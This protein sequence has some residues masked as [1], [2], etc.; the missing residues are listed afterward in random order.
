MVKPFENKAMYDIYLPDIP[1][2]KNI[3]KAINGIKYDGNNRI[4]SDAEEL[5]ILCD[6][7]QFVIKPSKETGCGKGVRK[8]TLDKVEEKQEYIKDLIKT[9]GNDYVISEVIEQHPDVSRLNPTSLNTCRVTTMNFNGKITS[10]TVLKVGKLNADKDNWCTSYLIGVGQNGD[11]MEYGYDA[12]LK[13]VTETDNGI[14]FGGIHLPEYSQMIIMVECFHRLYFPYIGVLGW[15]VV[16]DR[17]GNVR[18][19]EV[20]VDYPCIVGEQFASGPFF[21]ERRDDIIETLIN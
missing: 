19:I 21:K 12:K 16:V 14:K 7:T 17:D 15:D 1:I 18:V 13:Q 6:S 2:A 4:I 9:Y 11:L 3:T 20:N 8:I 10:S 5:E